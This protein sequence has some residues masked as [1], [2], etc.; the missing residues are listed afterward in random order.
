MTDPL[1]AVLDL[2]SVSGAVAATLSAGGT[3]GLDLAAVPGAAFHAV[4]AGSAC[5]LVAGADPVR[6]HPGDV[7]LLPGGLAHRLA[8]EPTSAVVP[9]DHDAAQAALEEGVDLVLSDDAPTTRILCASYRH[10][11]VP[12]FPAFE[13]LPPVLCLRAATAPAGLRSVLDLMAHET[14]TPAPGRRIVLDRLVDVLLIQAVRAYLQAPGSAQLPPSWLRGLADPVVARTMGLVH[15][16]PQRPWSTDSLAR[17]ANVSRATLN[18][19]FL[20]QVG[21]S[22]GRYLTDWRLACA[23]MLLSTGDQPV[24]SVARAVGYTSEYAFNRAFTRRHGRPPGRY[25][26]TT[27]PPPDR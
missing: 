6:L 23:A 10:R 2:A 7:V 1:A 5:L 15:G 8:A 11:P 3:W 25:R 16:S 24:A 12:G 22:P 18:R 20:A 19:R 26:T 21:R 27:A 9:F 13:L 17:A 14:A 4:T